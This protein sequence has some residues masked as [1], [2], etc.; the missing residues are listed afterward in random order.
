MFKTTIQKQS[1]MKKILHILAATFVLMSAFST[2]VKAQDNKK[3]METLAKNYEDA[4]NKKDAKAIKEFYTKDAVRV[5][6]DGT[7]T[8]GSE[9]IAADATDFFAK[10]NATISIT[11]SNCVTE[12]DGSLT[13][14]GTYKGSAGGND[15]GGNYTNTCVKEDG[16]W[17]ISKSVVTSQ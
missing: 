14:T 11:V 5:N 3:E 8:N 9:A 16:E 15:F 6:P 12:T 13:A 17:K 7:T 10:N 4:Y 1:K 2:P